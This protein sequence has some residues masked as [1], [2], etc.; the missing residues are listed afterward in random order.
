MLVVSCEM[1][2][3]HFVLLCYFVAVTTSDAW[4]VIERKATLNRASIKNII[5]ADRYGNGFD[6]NF[7]SIESK[8]NQLDK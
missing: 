8:L 3:R 4:S 1:F 5:N 6:M 7:E 2:G